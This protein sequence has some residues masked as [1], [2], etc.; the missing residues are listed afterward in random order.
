MFPI[1]HLKKPRVRE[2]ARKFKLP[3]ADKKDSQGICFIGKVK[4]KD[5]LA[6]RIPSKPGQIVTIHGEIVGEHQGLAPFTIGQRHGLGLSGGPWFV[7]RKEMK[8]NIL[9]VAHEKDEKALLS[10]GLVFGKAHWI[11][12]K[13]PRLPLKCRA[14]IRYRQPLQ[15]V[16]VIRKGSR[17][18]WLATFARRQRAVTPGQ[19]VAFYDGEVCLGGGV[20]IRQLDF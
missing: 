17:G 19:F 18:S 10:R 20:I 3:V 13:P 14:R 1:G 6:K 4:L 5:F 9:V 12:G 15:A 11:S 8:K 16:T 7:V 2:L